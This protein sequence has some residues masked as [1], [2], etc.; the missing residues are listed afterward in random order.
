MTAI[1]VS[2]KLLGEDGSVRQGIVMVKQPGQFLPKFR[3]TS[4]HIFMQSPQNVAVE[5]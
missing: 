5:L 3:A 4:S 2:P 1:Y